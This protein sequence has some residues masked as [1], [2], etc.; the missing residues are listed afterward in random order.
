MTLCLTPGL[1]LTSALASPLQCAHAKNA[2]ANPLESALAK[3][4]HLKFPEMNTYKKCGGLPPPW[5]S[6]SS[7]VVRCSSLLICGGGP[8]PSCL[9]QFWFVIRVHQC[10]SVVPTFSSVRLC[11]VLPSAFTSGSGVLDCGVRSRK[12]GTADAWNFGLCATIPRKPRQARKGATV[13]GAL[14]VPRRTRS[15]SHRFIRILL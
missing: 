2:S 12:G 1:C 8:S 13:A 14:R 11:C 5:L 6:Q 4:L 7:F 9:L 10:S 3:S 15:S